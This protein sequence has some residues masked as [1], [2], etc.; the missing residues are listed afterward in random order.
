MGLSKI[1]HFDTPYNV[2]GEQTSK[3]VFEIVYALCLEVFTFHNVGL[4]LY[5]T[6]VTYA[7][8]LT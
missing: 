2:F 6:F 7:S 8:G 3:N 1:E 5:F 4:S